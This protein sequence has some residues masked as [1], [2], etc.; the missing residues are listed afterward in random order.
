MLRTTEPSPSVRPDATT[1][2]CLVFL[3]HQ[4]APERTANQANPVSPDH[5]VFPA[6]LHWRSARK[7]PHHHASHA[8]QDHPDH[9]VHLANLVPLAPTATPAVLARMVV[10]DHPA[11]PAPTAHLAPLA[12]TERR[13]PLVNPPFQF[14]QPLEML[15][16]LART[17]HPDQPVK[18]AP[19]AQTEAPAQLA[20]KAHP[21]R[22]ARPATTALL[23]T[24]DHL[25]QMAPRENRVFAPNIAPPMVVSSSKMEQDDK[26]PQ[27]T[28]TRFCFSDEK[29]VIFMS[30]VAFIF[31][32][33][34]PP[35]SKSTILNTAAASPVI[36]FG[37][38]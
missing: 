15:D 37:A 23:A 32:F 19:P 35:Q 22:L 12:R 6:A 7:C 27:K 33:I 11:Q 10:T 38:L 24:R 17:D 18:T 1:A 20:T 25:A 5:P 9:L 3:A 28:F 29:P 34:Q 26:R 13:D 4:D 30:I 8:H 31:I 16:P 14:H 2:A 36:S 21:D